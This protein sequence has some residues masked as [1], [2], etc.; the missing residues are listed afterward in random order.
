MI[1]A[2]AHNAV[3]A[4]AMNQTTA[5]IRDE[6]LP[7]RGIKGDV[8]KRSAVVRYVGEQADCATT[9]VDAPDRTRSA[10]GCRWPKKPGHKAGSW[11][12]APQAAQQTLGIRLGSDDWQAV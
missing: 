11:L 5:A 8:A 3:E 7:V 10:V 1:V 6:E 2:V 4:D 12:A 9:P